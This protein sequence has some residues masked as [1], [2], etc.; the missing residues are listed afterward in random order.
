MNIY[1]SC[2]STN[3]FFIDAVKEAVTTFGKGLEPSAIT[4]IYPPLRIGADSG[5]VKENVLMIRSSDIVIFDVT[6]KATES[7]ENTSYNP[8]VMIEFGIVLS[9]EN[10]TIGQPWGGKL[11][12]PSYRL[13]CSRGYS[14]TRLTPLLN[15]A[16]VIPYDPDDSGKLEKEIVDLINHKVTERMNIIIF[17]RNEGNILPTKEGIQITRA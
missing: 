16:S 12:K 14:R 5:N 13:F 9:Q 11:P 2:D 7:E 15:E 4:L 8:G 10:P 1:L 17:Y 3:S 6:P